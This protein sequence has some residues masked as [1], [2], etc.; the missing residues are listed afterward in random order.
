MAD[1]WLGDRKN[2]YYK[3][4][5]KAIE[6]VWGEKPFYIREGGTIPVTRLLEKVYSFFFKKNFFKLP[7]NQ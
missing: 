7:S 3:A 1:W 5:E 2:R 4:A 6:K